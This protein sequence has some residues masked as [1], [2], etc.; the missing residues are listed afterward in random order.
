MKTLY[1]KNA[2]GSMQ[3]WTIS[4]EGATIVTRFGQVGGAIQEAR[5]VVPAGKGKR[6]V[7]EQAEAEALSR[8]IKQKK[9]KSYVETRVA[10]EAGEVDA[11]VEGGYSPM[12]AHRYDQRGDDIVFPAFVQPKFDGHR[13]TAD[14]NRQLWSRTRKPIT[15]L[16]HIQ[17]A[18][19]ALPP[20][21]PDG[22]AYH[23]DY[24]NR[25]EELTHFIRSSTPEPGFDIVQ[26]HIY[27]VNRPGTFRERFAWLREKFSYVRGSIL[28]LAETIEVKDEDEML[29]VRERF[30]AAGYEGLMVRNANGLYVGKRSKDLQKL[31]TFIDQDYPVV[32]VEEGRGKLAGHAIFVC[33]GKGG[34][35]RA[36]MRGPLAELKTFWE[37]PERAIGRYLTVKYQ[38]LTKYDLPRFPVAWRLREE[39]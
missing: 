15:A 28:H 5:D 23:H 31:K 2:N 6:S 25:F 38:G 8:W 14:E 26:Y 21:L 32:G 4:V 11:L 37:N 18:L 36:K 27:D 35:F 17:N 12:L 22:E 13:M 16:P 7:Q 1:K 3:E 9:T 30:V 34:E 29:L 10:A 19:K 33:Q 20:C 39:L 24:H